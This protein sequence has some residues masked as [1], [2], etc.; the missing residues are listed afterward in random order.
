MVWWY[1]TTYTTHFYNNFD[2]MGLVLLWQYRSGTNWHSRGNP[3]R[4]TKTPHRNWGGGISCS[5]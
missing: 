5:L 3:S 2:Y 4:A 1:H